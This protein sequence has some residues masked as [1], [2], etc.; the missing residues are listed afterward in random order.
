MSDWIKV[1]TTTSQ[2]IEV[3]T[4]ADILDMDEHTVFGKL[5]ILWCWADAHTVDGNAASV[6]KKM[7]DRITCNA[8]FAAAMLH[9]NVQWLVE[10]ERGGLSF[11]NF[12]R[13]NGKGAK[14]R[15]V[16]ARR[17]QSHRNGNADVT[18]EGATCNAAS[19]TKALPEKRREEK[20]KEIGE[21]SQRFAPPTVQDVHLYM[22]EKGN[23]ELSEA[24]KFCDH[25]DSNGWIVGRAKMKDWKATARNWLR[26]NTTTQ[27]AQATQE[28]TPRMFGE[29]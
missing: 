13:H 7:I 15:S 24:E 27:A 29:A 10:D 17:V 25:Y 26:R 23:S 1:E 8:G 19:V 12:D 4:M 22:T 6:T 11:P 18:P 16:T 21:K 14:K 20:S 2:K 5:V 28:Y 9:E 3:L